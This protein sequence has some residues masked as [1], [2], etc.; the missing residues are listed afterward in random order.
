MFFDLVKIRRLVDEATNLAVRA[1]TGVASVNQQTISSAHH[2]AAALGLGIGFGPGGQTK[3]SRERKHRM[4]EQATQKLSKAYRLDEIASSV[5]TMQS[6]SP[7][8]EVASLVLQRNAQDADAKYVHF[9]HEKIPSRHLAESTSLA[10]LDDII[11][12]R[13]TQGEPLRTRATVRVFKGDLQGAVSDLTEALKIH[14]LYWPSHGGPEPLPVVGQPYDKPQR[15]GRRQE[16]IILKEDDQPSSLE[17][18]LLFQRAGIYLAVA[19]QNVTAAFSPVTPTGPPHGKQL[20]P[21]LPPNG[22]ADANDASEPEADPDPEPALT[23]AQR[24]AR[25]LVRLNA[26]R[27]LRDY[28]AFLSHLE[29][30]PDFPIDIA[31]EFARKVNY[32]ANGVRVPRPQ[33]HHPRS[34]SPGSDEASGNYAT[35]RIFTLSELFTAAPLS[36]LPP[37][38]STALAVVRPKPWSCPPE[39]LTTTETLTYHPLLTDALHSLLLCHCLA[40]TSAKELLRHAYMVAR[41]SRLADGYP[42]FQASRSPARADWIEVLRSG[43]NWI[44]LVGSWEELCAPALIPLLLPPANGTG[45][46][47]MSSAQSVPA[48]KRTKALTS[49]SHENGTD[50]NMED[51]A[52]VRSSGFEGHKAKTEKQR[53]DRI[54]CQA[55][56]E[57]LGDDRVVD[58]LSLHQAIR[59]RQIRAERDYC[60]DNAVAALDAKFTR[61][62]H[63]ALLAADSPKSTTTVETHDGDEAAGAPHADP[64]A[65]TRTTSNRSST[66]GSKST[67][68]DNGTTASSSTTPAHRGQRRWAMDDGSDF[69]ILTDRAAAV[70][71]WVLEAPPNAGLGSAVDGAARKRRKKP[72]RKGIGLYDASSPGVMAGNGRQ[73]LEEAKHGAPETETPA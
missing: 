37:Y 51:G 42:V 52:V 17:I 43:N 29:Y 73:D 3:L 8:E 36:D 62:E 34:S 30:S 1:A 66:N 63:E 72:A 39:P 49:P 28:M 68:S 10:A 24:E 70:T 35:H 13:P 23:P 54:H 14:R 18:Q 56:L 44:Q 65:F 40:Q 45:L 48:G 59:A 71:Q 27:A 60:L 9:F 64:E 50:M 12:E 22:R 32:A 11:A 33:G 16:D 46:V 47:S 57:A 55:M 19:C 38:P 58:D 5:A 7:L 20:D 61:H 4:R 69:P 67:L 31:E 41:L 6:A 21:S 15:T 53:K 25:K 2:H 26:K